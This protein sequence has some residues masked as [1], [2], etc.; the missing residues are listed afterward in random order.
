MKGWWKGSFPAS[1][2]SPGSD[3]TRTATLSP[4]WS[5]L[6]PLRP[7]WR[8][9]HPFTPGGSH[10][11]LAASSWPHGPVVALTMGLETEVALS[12]GPGAWI[13][14]AQN[15][16]AL[17]CSQTWSKHPLRALL[18]LALM[19]RAS[20]PWSPGS[21]LT[22]VQYSKKS[23]RAMRC[24]PPLPSLPLPSPPL[25]SP[26]LPSLPEM[27]IGSCLCSRCG[28][29]PDHRRRLPCHEVQREPG[30]RPQARLSF[31]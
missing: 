3:P 5:P 6:P 17:F 30:C 24:L 11:A 28:L 21:L 4:V 10:T 18:C 12:L 27:F 19:E 25:C 8:L 1:P 15:P 13:L 29:G 26:L 23:Q 31:L 16:P 14:D 9:S 22:R 7:P 2:F 20:W